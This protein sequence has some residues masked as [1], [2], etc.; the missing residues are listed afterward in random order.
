MYG[1]QSWSIKKS[2]H[3]RIDAFGLWCWRRC[4]RVPWT[5]RRSKQSIL[6]VISPKYSLERLILKLKLQYFECLMQ[7]ADAPILWV[8]DAKSWLIGKDPDAGKDWRR[9]EKRVTEDEMDGRHHLLNGHE[10][11]KLGEVVKEGSVTRCGVQG[12]R[13]GREWVTP[14]NDGIDV[15]FQETAEKVDP[16]KCVK[17]EWRVLSKCVIRKNKAVAGLKLWP[18]HKGGFIRQGTS[19]LLAFLR[20]LVQL[21]VYVRAHLC[22][23][24]CHPMDCRPPDSFVPGIFQ[25]QIFVCVV[26]SYSRESSQPKDWNHVSCMSSLV[27]RVFLFFFLIYFT[28]QYC[29]GF[30][31]RWLE[32]TMSVHVFPILNAPSTSLA[33]PSLWV[34]PVHQSWALCIM[35]QTWTGDSFH[36]WY[37]TCFNSLPLVPPESSRFSSLLLLYQWND[38][39]YY[40]QCI[41]KKKL[42]VF[43]GLQRKYWQ[44]FLLHKLDKWFRNN[45]W[46]PKC[47]VTSP[48]NVSASSD[49]EEEN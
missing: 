10:L 47:K 8:P 20:L 39:T 27:G 5:A 38:G 24:L 26:I 28:L 16:E 33:I 42:G 41:K 31:I 34:I 22:P 7:R 19:L 4:L 23:T 11:S 43:W 13:E 32:S 9:E 12:H 17:W 29:I 1:C 2:E 46:T 3:E 30:V 35:H 18:I 25:G 45:P 14:T 40:Y 21:F 48:N 37:F 6:K 49:K 36:I 44:D 15:R